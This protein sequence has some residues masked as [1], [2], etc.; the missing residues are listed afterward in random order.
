MLEKGGLRSTCA[1]LELVCEMRYSPRSRVCWLQEELVELTEAMLTSS[2]LK[3]RML[4][5]RTLR[6]RVLS[7][8]AV[9]ESE[10]SSSQGVRMASGYGSRWQS[11]VS[12]CQLSSYN[13][14]K[15]LK[16]SPC[17]EMLESRS[18]WFRGLRNIHLLDKVGYEA[19]VPNLSLFV[20]MVYSLRSG[21]C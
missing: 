1:K 13:R 16:G 7:A 19:H 14:C 10:S 6:S 5:S 8:S 3:G 11:R 4:R 9:V 15:L 17:R 20:K 2:V 12:L 18:S 21:E